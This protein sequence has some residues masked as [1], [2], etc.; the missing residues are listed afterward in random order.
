MTDPFVGEILLM[1]IT[2]VPQGFADCNGQLLA[3]NQNQALFSLLGTTF[4]GNG[5]TNFALPDLRGRAPI[6]FGQGSGLTSYT[7]GGKGGAETVA[8]NSTQM[9]SHQHTPLCSSAVGNQ[10]APAG[11]VWAG[12]AN[13]NLYST[14]TPST[15]MYA[16]AVGSAGN[17]QA[18]E[19]R[20]PV[21]A[22][23]YVIAL[24]GVY[25][26]RP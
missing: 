23:R 11:N 2:Y 6:H 4:G 10:V 9:P 26:S 22:L 14:A 17:N 21:L 13:D 12:S 3:I 7:L 20:Q 16:A 8:L 24:V 25:P 18:H 19:N 1:A 15:T 5:T